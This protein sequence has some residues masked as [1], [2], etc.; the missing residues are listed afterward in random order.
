MYIILVAI[1]LTILGTVSLQKSYF[2]SD[3]ASAFSIAGYIAFIISFAM[4]EF[5]L[6]TIHIAYLFGIWAAGVTLLA[7]IIGRIFYN[8]RLSAGKIISLALVFVGLLG[9][10]LS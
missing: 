4:L 10:S 2:G 9:L 5:S 1:F 8:E 7:I 6:I 3:H